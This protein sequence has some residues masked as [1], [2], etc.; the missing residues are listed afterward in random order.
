MIAEKAETD[1]QKLREQMEAEVKAYA[2][3]N[4]CSD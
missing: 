3:V 4:I 1:K 2:K